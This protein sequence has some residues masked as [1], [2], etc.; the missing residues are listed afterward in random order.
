MCSWPGIC[1]VTPIFLSFI[2]S[3]LTLFSRYPLYYHRQENWWLRV[4]LSNFES[5][6]SLYE[7]TDI[8]SKLM[9]D[10]EVQEYLRNLVFKAYHHIRFMLIY[11]FIL[12]HLG[13][14]FSEFILLFIFQWSSSLILL[15]MVGF[16]FIFTQEPEVHFVNEENIS[17]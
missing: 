7:T 3:N 14:K 15:N 9:N 10:Y 1:S 16:S 2:L 17:F 12:L 11:W 5:L 13:H 4:T 6:D 8:V